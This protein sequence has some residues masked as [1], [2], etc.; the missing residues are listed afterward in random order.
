MN[1]LSFILQYLLERSAKISLRMIGW[2]LV[3]ELPL[4]QKFLLVG[5]PHTS[6]WD[7]PI[8]LLMMAGLGLRLRWIGKDALFRGIK[9][10]IMR[11]LGGIPVKRGARKNF[12]SQIVDLYNSRDEMV[13][14]IAPEGTRKYLDHWKT[15]FYHIA[16]NAKIPVALGFVD[17]SKKTC[18]VG[19]YF[20]PSGDQ[21]ADLEILQEFY[22]D[23]TGKFPHQENKIRFL[24]SKN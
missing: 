10:P 23:K 17:Y 8:A 19:G 7:F 4:T 2:S 18:G 24:A 20:I 21:A 22:D 15:G 12:V 16:L 6:N 9:G 5:A 11:G 3:A 1:I 13:I 14:T